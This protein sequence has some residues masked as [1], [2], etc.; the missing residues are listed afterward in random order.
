MELCKR[1]HG[2]GYVWKPALG[3]IWAIIR[4]KSEAELCPQ[5][6]GYQATVEEILAARRRGVE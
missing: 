2:A 5:C 3:A 1:C 6:G 4:H